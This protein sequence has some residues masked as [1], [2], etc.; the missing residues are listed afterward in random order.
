VK[1][2]H[3][4]IKSVTHFY[5]SNWLPVSNEDANLLG[6][7]ALEAGLDQAK[8]L[9]TQELTKDRYIMEVRRLKKVFLKT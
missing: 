2:I 1:L 3:E 5:H 4:L 7:E 9:N 8:S 6:I